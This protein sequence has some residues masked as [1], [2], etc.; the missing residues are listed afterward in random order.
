MLV[1]LCEPQGSGSS[2]QLP[3]RLPLLHFQVF[4][5]DLERVHLQDKTAISTALL[6]SP[7]LLLLYLRCF[8]F[9]CFCFYAATHLSPPPPLRRPLRGLSWQVPNSGSGHSGGGR[10]SCNRRCARFVQAHR[11]CP[12]R[13]SCRWSPAYLA[14]HSS[15]RLLPCLVAQGCHASPAHRA[16]HWLLAAPEAPA[17]GFQPAPGCRGCP[18]AQR[19]HTPL[20]LR[21]HPP[22]HRVQKTPPVRAGPHS[23]HNLPWAKHERA[24]VSE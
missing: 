10:R 11:P 3:R 20:E 7:L 19:H 22:S 4:A 16:R 5:L 18:G 14:P 17:P 13:R 8:C 24:T 15:P 12:A 21:G 1:D 9:H 2:H 6:A 23:R